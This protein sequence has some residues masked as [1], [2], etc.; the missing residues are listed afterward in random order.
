MQ[1]GGFPVPVAPVT[2]Y[3]AKEA[4]AVIGYVDP[5]WADI[6]RAIITNLQIDAERVVE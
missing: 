4:I 5:A 1:E 2:A 6:Q 3:A